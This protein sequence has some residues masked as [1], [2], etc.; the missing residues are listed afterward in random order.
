[1]GICSICEAKGMKIRTYTCNGCGEEVCEECM[2]VLDRDPAS[3]DSIN[4]N[5]IHMCANCT[6]KYIKDNTKKVTGVVGKVC[7]NCGNK[8]TKGSFRAVISTKKAM[9][10]EGMEFSYIPTFLPKGLYLHVE[11]I[12]ISS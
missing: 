7:P 4:K 5:G 8:I 2:E 6:A 11:S 3:L 12:F 1:M 10:A 9:K